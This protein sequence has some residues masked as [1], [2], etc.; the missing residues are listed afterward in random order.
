MP[1]TPHRIDPVEC[2]CTDCITGWSQ[3]FSRYGEPLQFHLLFH[4]GVQD[5]TGSED[6]G[7]MDVAAKHCPT[8]FAEWIAAEIRAKRVLSR[9]AVEAKLATAMLGSLLDN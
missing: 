6:F 8:T 2:G 7:W 9:Q 3:P 4:N 1:P 5:A